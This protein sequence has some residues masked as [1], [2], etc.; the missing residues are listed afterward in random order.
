MRNRATWIGNLMLAKTHPNFPSDLATLMTAAVRSAQS[1][2]VIAELPC[3]QRADVS[4]STTAGDVWISIAYAR[5]L[6]S[7]SASQLR[8]SVSLVGN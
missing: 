5:C 6:L 8:C 7:C 2:L 1:A 3:L 4:V